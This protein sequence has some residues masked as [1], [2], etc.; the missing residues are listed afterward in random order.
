MKESP[1]RNKYTETVDRESA[2]EMLAARA[3]EAAKAAQGSGGI[4]GWLGGILGGVQPRRLRVVVA[5]HPVRSRA[6]PRRSR[7]RPP[8]PWRHPWGGRS[9]RP[10]CAACSGACSVAGGAK[11][12]GP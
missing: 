1:F 4:G 5:R 7:P 6:W 9:A 10:S 12:S 2:F 8:V 3:E 11:A